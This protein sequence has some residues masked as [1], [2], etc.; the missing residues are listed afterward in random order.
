M[1]KMTRQKEAC[2]WCYEPFVVNIQVRREQYHCLECGNY[3]VVIKDPSSAHD[4]GKGTSLIFD[5]RFN[6]FLFALANNELQEFFNAIKEG[7]PVNPKALA[8][9]QKRV[10]ARKLR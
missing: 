6:N 1:S 2:P 10:E 8:D 9:C 7:L 4:K 3:L 5:L